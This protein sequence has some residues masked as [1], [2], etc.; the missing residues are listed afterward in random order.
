MKYEIKG[1]E[2]ETREYPY[3]GMTDYVV[4]LFTG[5]NTGTIIF[6]QNCSNSRELGETRSNWN[7]NSFTSLPK[8]TVLEVTL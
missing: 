6:Q 7:E 1:K 4:V 2:M 5:K 8:G 3:Y